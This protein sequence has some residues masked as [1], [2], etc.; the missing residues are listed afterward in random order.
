MPTPT[1]VSTPLNHGSNTTETLT[2]SQAALPEDK[3]ATQFARSERK[4]SEVW[5]HMVKVKKMDKTLLFVI[6]VRLSLVQKSD[7]LKIHEGEIEGFKNLL[8]VNTGRIAITTDIWNSRNKKRF[9]YVL[10]LH[11]MDVIADTLLKG[12][13]IHM[14]CCAHILNL[15]VKDGL[16]VID[17]AI[18]T[19]RDSVEYWIATPSRYKFKVVEYYFLR[20]YKDQSGHYSEEVRNIMYELL[21]E[22]QANPNTDES[23]PHTYVSASES[24]LNLPGDKGVLLTWLDDEDEKSMALHRLMTNEGLVSSPE[25]EMRR[26]L[27]IQKLKQIVSSWI[28]KGVWNRRLLKRHISI[29]SATVLTFGSYGL[30]VH[31]PKFD[32]DTLCVAPFVTSMVDDFFISLHVMLEKRLKISDIHCVKSAKV[33]LMRLKFDGISID[34]P[35]T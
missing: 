8:G 7:I 11:T 25:E 31:S 22:Y 28:K 26:K 4:R 33:P 18:E 19:I 15:I 14:H 34:L 29:T 3:G 6:T 1:H 13:I 32:I 27:A 21:Q 30:G 17:K 9:L 16:S 20:I 2:S 24:T 10:T 12:R 23:S 35:I 5:N